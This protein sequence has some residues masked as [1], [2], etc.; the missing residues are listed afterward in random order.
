MFELV[1]FENLFSDFKLMF[2]NGNKFA[3]F[4]SVLVVFV[5]FLVTFSNLI[6]KKSS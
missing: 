3:L 5:C 2:L 1:S 4:L 6:I